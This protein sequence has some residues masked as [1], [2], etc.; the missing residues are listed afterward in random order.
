MLLAGKK[1]K[2]HIR[3]KFFSSY[4]SDYAVCK[5]ICH[6]YTS[7][8]RICT[9][10][11]SRSVRPYVYS[12][13]AFARIADE[14]C[15]NPTG[16]PAETLYFLCAYEDTFM[17]KM[18]RQPPTDTT[19]DWRS[20]CE[21]GQL[22]IPVIDAMA[23]TAQQF[24]LPLEYFSAFFTSMKKDIPGSPDFHSHYKTMDDLN[25][26]IYGSAEVFGLLMLPFLVSS[27]TDR[28]LSIVHNSAK[29]LGAAFQRTNF[30]RDI[31]EDY[32]R[33][34]MYLPQELW[35]KHGIDNATV[36]HGIESAQLDL[37]MKKSLIEWN[38]ATLELY[39]QAYQGLT[40]IDLRIRPMIWLCLV[41][42]RAIS[43]KIDYLQ[44]TPIL[45]QR[46]TLSMRERIKAILDD[47][48][49]QLTGTP[50]QL[51]S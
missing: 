39:A 10:L 37:A 31:L 43:L 48:R 25:E 5:E 41:F 11:L 6:Q 26:Y 40:F 45:Y 28:Q 15:D 34:R 17:R 16:T 4:S 8:F 29:A 9:S 1:I 20:S 51:K 50:L 36:Q 19:I 35:K 14:I 46:V 30:L 42:Y 22:A 3:H 23:H 32:Q 33:G 49:A 2:H 21:L 24:Q 18:H 38:S 12:L 47:R 7:T 13:Y 44:Y 27:V